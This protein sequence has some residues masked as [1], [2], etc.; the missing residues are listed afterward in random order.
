MDSH[1]PRSA[2]LSHWHR[3]GLAAAVILEAVWLALLATLAI[4]R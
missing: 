2:E 1:H 4:L 3:W